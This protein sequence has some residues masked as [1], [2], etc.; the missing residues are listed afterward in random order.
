MQNK[1]DADTI[2]KRLKL[3]RKNLNLTQKEFSASVGI[4]QGNL[5]EMEKGKFLPS[6]DTLILIIKQYKISADWIL[7]GENTI[8]TNQFAENAEIREMHEV[9]NKVMSDP[10][11]E[12]R[13]WAKIQFRKAFARYFSVEDGKID[14]LKNEEKK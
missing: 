8:H 2:G 7:T 13:T 12:I 11:L 3:L 10:N 1:D 9:I 5:S 4:S 6:Y 14:D